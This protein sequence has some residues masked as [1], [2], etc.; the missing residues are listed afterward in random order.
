MKKGGCELFLSYYKVV[1]KNGPSFVRKRYTVAYKLVFLYVYM[2]Q[3]K[4]VIF[5]L[6]A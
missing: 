4:R 6:F 2:H 1:S 3:K 5:L